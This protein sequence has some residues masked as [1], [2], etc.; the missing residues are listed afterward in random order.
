MASAEDEDIEAAARTAEIKNTEYL[1]G[2]SILRFEDFLVHYFFGLVL[3]HCT[4]RLLK[5]YV[6]YV[7]VFLLSLDSSNSTMK[8][9]GTLTTTTTVTCSSI[10]RGLNVH[11]ISGAQIL[12]RG[13][14]FSGKTHHVLK[15]GGWRDAREERQKNGAR[16]NG[17]PK[18]IGSLFLSSEDNRSN[19]GR[20]TCTT[21]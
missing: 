13:Q 15:K 21:T 20:D 19:G 2:D 11:E 4:L 5:L 9:Q 14:P 1:F 18:K 16:N 10:I 17:R 8:G 3:A 7:V 6:E 12:L